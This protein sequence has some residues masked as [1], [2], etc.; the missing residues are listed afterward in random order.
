MK[1]IQINTTPKITKHIHLVNKEDNS[2]GLFNKEFLFIRTIDTIFC[3]VRT[4]ISFL[5]ADGNYTEIHTSDGKKILSSKTLKHFHQIL[6][7]TFFLRSHQSYLVNVSH[8][9]KLNI[10]QGCEMVMD[11]GSIIPVSKSRQSH[12]LSL[13]QN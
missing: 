5:K 12:I 13:F 2:S 6:E 11:C 4:D 3:I 10:H 1:T 7:G 8:L 9:I